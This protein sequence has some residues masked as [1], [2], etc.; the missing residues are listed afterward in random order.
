MREEGGVVQQLIVS[1]TDAT[2]LGPWEYSLSG[3][4]WA[5][6][7]KSLVKNLTANNMQMDDDGDFL[8]VV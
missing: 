5:T 7:T 4:D 6:M 1:K 8:R 3:G 2:W